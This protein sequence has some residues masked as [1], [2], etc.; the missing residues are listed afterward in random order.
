MD[1]H[2]SGLQVYGGICKEWTR[3]ETGQSG[4]RSWL[5]LLLT[6]G[7]RIQ[8]LRPVDCST[9]LKKWQES[10]AFF[11]KKSIFSI[12]WI[13]N[14]NWCRCKKNWFKYERGWMVDRMTSRFKEWWHRNKQDIEIWKSLM[15]C[16][17][18]DCKGPQ[19]PLNQLTMEPDCIKRGHLGREVLSNIR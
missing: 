1:D 6:H 19:P 16:I 4:P 10:C 8:M 9:K 3:A 12:I 14:Q 13:Q 15:H 11:W 2:A 18:Y 17:R 5:A 7:A